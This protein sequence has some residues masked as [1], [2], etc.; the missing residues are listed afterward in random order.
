MQRWI[1]VGVHRWFGGFVGSFVE[2]E[3]CDGVISLL[4]RVEAI[5]SRLEAIAIRFLLKTCKEDAR[6]KSQ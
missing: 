1:G 4:R 3:D 6:K 5:A 2:T